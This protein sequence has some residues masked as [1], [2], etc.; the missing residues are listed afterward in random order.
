MDNKNCDYSTVELKEDI[1]TKPSE[2]GWGSY[3]QWEGPY[4]IGN[5][6]FTISPSPSEGEKILAVI[7]A[8]EGGTFSAVNMYDSCVLSS[9]LIQWCEAQYSVSGMI[10]WLA[11][12]DA[13][14]LD[15]LQPAMALSNASFK[16]RT[17]GK[18]RFFFNDSRGEV[19]SLVKQQI[20]FFYRSTGLKGSWDDTSKVHAKTWAACIASLWESKIAQQIQTEYT[21][22][23]LSGFLTKDAETILYGQNAPEDGNDLADALRAAYYS[24]A[25]NLPAVASEQLRLA[26]SQTNALSWSEAWVIDVLRQLTFG[27]KISIYPDRYNKIR[28]VLE[29]LYNVNLPDFASDLEK[30]VSEVGSDVVPGMTPNFLDIEEVQIELIAEGYDL[31]PKGADGCYGPKTKQAIREF[32]AAHCLGVDGVVGPN[33]RRAL[34]DEYVKRTR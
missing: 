6:R 18:W 21:T 9:G 16:R 24:F 8:T 19:N 15:P 28:P 7:T 32:Q 14:L 12:R 20:L 3:R 34:V 13:S 5:N 11:A 31:G 2:I 23:K 22:N 17:D 26:V 27:P 33:T 4:F 29:R 25:A 10:G 1:M 30:L